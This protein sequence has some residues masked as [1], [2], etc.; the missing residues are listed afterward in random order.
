[1]TA[2]PAQFNLSDLDG[3]NGFVLN[4][5]ATNVAPVFPVSGA[6]DFNGDGIDDI[7]IGAMSADP[8]G[9]FSGVSYVVFGDTQE[10]RPAI[11]FT[12]LDGHNGFAL[13]GVAGGDFSG[14]SVSGAGDINDDGI[15]DVIIG[16]AGVDSNGFGSGASY[17][18]FGTEQGFPPALDLAALDGRNGFALNGIAADDSSGR[19]VSE[20]GDIN[21]DGIDDVIIGALRADSNGVDSGASYVVF[22][23]EQV[24]PP[25]LDLAILDGRNGFV[26]NGAAS[27]DFSGVVSG[28]GD[29]NGDGID[30][31]IIGA[32]GADPN[33]VDS[34]ASY[35]VFGTEQGF[36]PALDLAA[37]DGRNGFALNGIAA[38]DSSGRSVSEAGDINGDGIDDVIIGALRADSNGVD[39]GASYVVFGTEQVFPPTL[40]LA[41]LDGRNGFVLNGAASGDFSGVVSG[42]GDINGD[43]IDDVII[44]A[45]GADPNG[46]DSGAS[47]VVFGNNQGLPP[48][49]DLAVLDGR[50]GFVLNGVAAYDVSGYS[51][52]AVG[53]INGDGI[54][55]LLIGARSAAYNGHNAVVGYVV[56]GNDQGFPPALDLATLDGR[57]GFILEGVDMY[58]LSAESVSGA[59]D[60]NGDG[61]DDLM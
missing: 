14:S 31:V 33:G 27:G 56:F 36:P 50:N 10:F 51:V 37:L 4:E 32:A 42:A 1:M 39:S 18:V 44:G 49:L 16:A 60:I 54:D 61:I 3:Q 28:A 11:D 12:T 9:D 43:G 52:S 21:G 26:L 17:I 41:I 47:Y 29:I 25:T 30:D 8:N 24:F 48:A 58:D 35:I 22:G 6:G 2:F 5:A 20:A 59:G 45:A 40:D 38:D 19:S 23:T 15:D 53:D 13:N 57:N 34:G 55:D 46:V 7:I